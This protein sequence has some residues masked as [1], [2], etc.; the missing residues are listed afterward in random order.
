V[1][2]PAR[3]D[4]QPDDVVFLAMK[5]QHTG[6]ALRALAEAA[7]PDIAVVCAQ[8]GVA[9]EREA[10]RYFAGVY[11]MC[12]MCPASHVEPGVVEASSEPITGLLDLGCYPAGVDDR[13]V[14]IAAALERSTFESV[15]RADI[16]R[17]K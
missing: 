7:P 12:V 2:H 5:G 16:M 6:D 3:L 9:N 17:W 8:N 11:A 1:D 15:P 13:A 14:A 4:L 10:L